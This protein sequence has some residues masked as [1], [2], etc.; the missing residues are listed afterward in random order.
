MQ[1]RRSS[2]ELQVP[3]FNLPTVY[4]ESIHGLHLLKID[5]I[6]HCLLVTSH[7]L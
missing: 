6:K 5:M 7:C 1:C 2:T 3:L 4:G